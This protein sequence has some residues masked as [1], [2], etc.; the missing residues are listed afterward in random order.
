MR[1]D[2][3]SIR[4]GLTYAAWGY[5]FLHVDINVQ[6]ISMTPDFVGDL[7]LLTAIKYLSSARRD[8]LLLRPLCVLMAVWHGIQWVPV[9]NDHVDIL[10]VNLL[11]YTVALYF[12][13][14]FFT[15]MAALAEDL[16]PPEAHL[17]RTLLRF[18]TLYALVYTA[19]YLLK[20]GSV[21]LPQ[22]RE[23]LT[24]VF[25]VGTVVWILI[26]IVLMA[27]LFSLRNCV[28]YETE[29]QNLELPPPE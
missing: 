15:D 11:F 5:L 23:S 22:Y 4:T 2:R 13:F 17:D 21:N 25:A 29:E 10:F 8:L 26:A 3:A 7:M 18:R 24:W 6:H 19:W 20:F 14:Q 16:Q 9:L 27:G 28:G 1:T 12:H